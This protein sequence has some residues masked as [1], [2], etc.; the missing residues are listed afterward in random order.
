MPCLRVNCAT[1]TPA[2]PSFRIATICDSVNRDFFMGPPWSRQSC[3]KSP[4]VAVYCEG[5]LTPVELGFD[6][7]FTEKPIDHHVPRERRP[8]NAHDVLRAI[9][10]ELGVI[11][12]Y[13]ADIQSGR[14]AQ[15]D[16]DH[17]RFLLAVE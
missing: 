8:F 1:V 16:G 10:H 4:V 12:V 13:L 7:L 5:K 2:S 15:D 17:A 11:V 9:V 14:A 6:A 3:Q